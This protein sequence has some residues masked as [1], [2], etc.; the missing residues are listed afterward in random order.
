M[1]GC[2][3]LVPAAALIPQIGD[4]WAVL[5][6]GMVAVLAHMAWLINL[7]ALVVDLVPNLLW[8]V[9]L[10]SSRRE[11][12]SRHFHESGVGWLVTAHSYDR[13]STSWWRCIRWR[14]CFCGG[15]ARVLFWPD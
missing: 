14:G 12:R 11:V 10:A 4:L 5:A 2:A 8:E 15:S 6:L 13:R 1:L 9:C 7:S 3:V